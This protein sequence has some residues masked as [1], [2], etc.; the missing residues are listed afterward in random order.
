MEP[1]NAP[2]RKNTTQPDERVGRGSS[3]PV[4][5]AFMEPYYHQQDARLGNSRAS[6]MPRG[7]RLTATTGS[8]LRSY[9]RGRGQ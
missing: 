1:S 7:D 2:S 9:R 3:W 6:V 5:F 8:M 4:G